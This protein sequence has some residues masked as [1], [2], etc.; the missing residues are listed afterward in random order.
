MMIRLRLG[1]ALVLAIA[2]LAPAA[3][4]VIY[5]QWNS[6]PGGDFCMP[7][8]PENIWGACVYK[9]HNPWFNQDPF[10]WTFP[11]DDPE[12][13]YSQGGNVPPEDPIVNQLFRNRTTSNWTDWHCT[14]TGGTIVEN[15]V[16]VK[17]YQ[18][19]TPV[20]HITY[21]PDGSGFYAETIAR[22]ET[23]I[24]PGGLLSV[25]FEYVGSGTV[26]FNQYPT[27]TAPIPEPASVAC[28]L[29]GLLALVGVRRKK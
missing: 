10:E 20:W 3:H 25:Y 2:A 16:V 6:G 28:L 26:T 18:N 11:T 29:S 27:T 8:D 22:S 9:V 15:S 14:I 17:N 5:Y 1:I 24:A 23:Y 12:Y 13:A 4:A 7:G 21:Y 19:Q